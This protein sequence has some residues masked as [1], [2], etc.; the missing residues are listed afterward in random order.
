MV[1]HVL[2]DNFLQA[3]ILSQ[4]AELSPGRMEAYEDLMQSL[5]AE[6]ML[7]RAIEFLPTGEEMAERRRSGRGMARP[8]LAV[9][10]A[11]AKQ[12]LAN[13]ILDSALPESEYLAAGPPVATSPRRWWS[14]SGTCSRSIRC[15]GS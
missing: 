15:V 2:Y 12:S 5:E 10:L 3:Q 9:L 13:A 14:G 1:E 7:E 6:G 8:E 11:Y 4:E